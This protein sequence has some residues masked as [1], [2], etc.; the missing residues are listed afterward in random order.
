[1]NKKSNDLILSLAPMAGLTDKAFR[2]ICQDWGVDVTWSEMVSS[3][4]LVRQPIENNKSLELSEKFG[5]KEKNYW[6]QL[7]GCDPESMAKAAKIIEEKIKPTG[8]NI[9]LG[10]PVKKAQKAG[11]G[12]I[13]MGKIPEVLEIIKAIKKETTLPLSLKTRVGLKNQEEILEF[14]P[15]L[16]KAGI[17]ELIVHARTL[18]GMFHETP[19]WEIVKK[20]TDTLTIPI[21]YNGGIKTFEDANFYQKKTEC[22]HLMIGQAAIGK[23]WI[24]W[25]IK[26]QTHEEPGL[27][28]IKETIL[29]HANLVLKH[30]G[31][32]SMMTFRTHLA[33]Y[34]K[35]RPNASALR[36][37]AVKI[38]TL[39]D[40]KKIIAKI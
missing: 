18:K 26:N 4:G 30:Y 6:V 13:Q 17:N 39:E 14:A 9:N 1:M 16:E 38:N 28:K 5:E 29:K 8:I 15:K 37:E 27:D 19:H 10:C 25:Q 2:E 21:T 32:K 22:D 34:L 12:A 40:V 20:L 33:A 7:F 31:E 23:P 24:F 36:K 35:G 11:Y 3:E